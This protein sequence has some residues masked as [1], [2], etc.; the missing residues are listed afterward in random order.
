[1]EINGC[2]FNWISSFVIIIILVCLYVLVRGSDLRSSDYLYCN[3][4]AL[5]ADHFIVSG[6]S[7]SIH[8]DLLLCSRALAVLWWS[9]HRYPRQ[10]LDT[11]RRQHQQSSEHR[12]QQNQVLYTAEISKQINSC[13]FNNV[14]RIAVEPVALMGLKGSSYN[15]SISISV[16][17]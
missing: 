13:I 9:C 7:T 15:S 4:T 6:F 16:F 8:S 5:S 11:S 10:Q 14:E 17:L 2:I 3:V 1:M 12:H